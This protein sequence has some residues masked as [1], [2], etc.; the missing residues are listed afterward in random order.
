MGPELDVLVGEIRHANES[1][2]KIESLLR[3]QGPK[4][5]GWENINS[6]KGIGDTGADILLST[7]GNIEGF[8]EEGQPTACFGLVPRASNSNET[9]R[10][11]RITERGC[12]L[13]RTA[14][15]NADQQG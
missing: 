7:I 10:S 1:I 4:L 2:K 3:D 5:P 12:K 11:R 9:E 13:G 8:A 14:S 15:G 6:I